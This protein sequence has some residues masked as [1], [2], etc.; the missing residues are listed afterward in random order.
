MRLRK[1]S[2]CVEHGTDM[3]T[4][5]RKTTVIGLAVALAVLTSAILG[6]TARAHDHKPPFVRLKADGVVQ[7]GIPWETW[8]VDRQADGGC[9]AQIVV[10]SGDFPS[11]IE[12]GRE[13]N[14]RI[15]LKK[16]HKPREVSITMWRRISVGEDEVL[17]PS[18]DVSLEL[19]RRRDSQG[20]TRAWDA[21]FERPVPGKYYYQAFVEWRDRQG[22]GGRQGGWWRFSLSVSP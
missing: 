18:E 22:C 19:Q 17:G 6:T 16:R 10:G 13:G 5:L 1:C 21:V 15:R 12:V 3:K 9:V 14:L 2:S 8:W 4:D 20:T 7:E 11:D